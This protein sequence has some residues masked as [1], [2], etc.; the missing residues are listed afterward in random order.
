[1][2]T[3]PGNVEHEP[4]RPPAHDPAP[5]TGQ[6]RRVSVNEAA[7]RDLLTVTEEAAHYVEPQLA[8]RIIAA[9]APFTAGQWRRS[10]P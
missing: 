2:A 1:M 8:D 9:T 7:L 5:Q 4:I 6:D 3:A 10:Q